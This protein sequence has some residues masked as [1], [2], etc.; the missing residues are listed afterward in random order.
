MILLNPKDCSQKC[1]KT[2]SFR[3]SIF[4]LMNI[5][6]II[7]ARG[8]SKGLPGKNIRPFSGYPLVAWSIIQSLSSSAISHTIVSTDSEEIRDIV[9]KYGAEVP[10]MRP[11]EFA[12]DH[13]HTEPVLLHAL[14]ELKKLG[15][16]PD[17]IVLLQPTSP[18]RLDGTLDRAIEVFKAGGYDSMLSVH[19]GH[20]FYWKNAADPRAQYDFKNRPRRQDVSE[21]ERLYAETGSIYITKTSVLREGENRLGGKIGLF[22]MSLEESFDID[23]EGDFRFLEGV[24]SRTTPL[25]APEQSKN[26]RPHSYAPAKSRV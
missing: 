3:D 25:T 20:H 7:P 14:D 26:P 16:E 22:P 1:G 10:F 9:L 11:A 23:T 18:I 5:I 15:E 2:R 12:A 13:S 8:G 6:S 21:S 4:C 17:A 19:A 24:A